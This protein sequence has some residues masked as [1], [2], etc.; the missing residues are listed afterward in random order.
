MKN[1]IFISAFEIKDIG[2]I[3]TSV[4]NFIRTIAPYFDIDLCVLS[5][6]ITP[7]YKFPKNVRIIPFSPLFDDCYG[8]KKRIKK[9]TIIG[10]IKFILLR[11]VRKVYGY[12]KTLPLVMNSARF[13]NEYDV[14]IAFWNDVYDDKGVMRMGGDY[15]NIINNV[16]A[17]KKIAWVHNDAKQLG[18]THDICKRV[19]KKFD[20]IVN[21]SYDCKKGFDD[22]IPEYEHKSH[23]VYNCYSIDEIKSKMTET[24]PY[25]NNGKLHFVT[26][27]RLEEQQKRVSRIVEVCNRLKSEG[28]NNF[29]WTI[30]GEGG[31]KDTYEASSLENGTT[32][33]L[34]FVGLRSNPYPYMKYADAFI[35][36]SLYEGFGMTIRE[37]QITGT[38]TFSTRFGAAEEAI[39][40]GKQGDIC[41]NSTEGIYEM[42][43]SI[44]DNPI[45]LKKYKNYVLDHPTTNMR[46]LNQFFDIINYGN[47]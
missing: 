25:E 14:A 46:S 29:D 22:L 9:T 39:E 17:K 20:A 41:D 43:K 32:D 23:V 10:K 16:R 42:I 15:Y 36:S 3:S 40:V 31:D 18:F 12:E 38:P 26:V 24:N 19:F 13:D 21:V 33:V 34:H 6:Y 47:I 8:D 44:L 5:N 11:L 30:V 28:Y 35:L 1:K 27:C 4:Y 7:R 37:A 45:I 2:G